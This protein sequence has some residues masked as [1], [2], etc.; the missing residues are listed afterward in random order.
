M[1][2]L[3]V[4]RLQVCA[5]ALLIA[6][7]TSFVGRIRPKPRSHLTSSSTTTPAWTSFR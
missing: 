6:G 1:T 7:A 5:A 2:A 4:R 3:I